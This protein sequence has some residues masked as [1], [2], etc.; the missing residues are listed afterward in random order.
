MQLLDLDRRSI[1]FR[2]DWWTGRFDGKIGQVC[3]GQATRVGSLSSEQQVR[4]SASSQCTC[5]SCVNLANKQQK[6]P[7]KSIDN[8]QRRNIFRSF[9]SNLKRCWQEFPAI[10]FNLWIWNRNLCKNLG[11]FFS[12]IFAIQPTI[13]GSNLVNDLQTCATKYFASQ[14]V[15]FVE[16]VARKKSQC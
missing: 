6:V 3:R 5:P 2:S 7:L 11:A 16:F 4:S 14:F 9:R 13:I 15:Q 1:W 10:L 8:E 12:K